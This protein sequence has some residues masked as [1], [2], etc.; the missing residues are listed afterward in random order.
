MWERTEDTI[1]LRNHLME[2]VNGNTDNNNNNNGENN[3]N[4]NDL[5]DLVQEYQRGQMRLYLLVR[6]VLVPHIS[7]VQVKAENTGIGGVYHNKGGIMVHVCLGQT[8]LTFLTAH[9]AAHEG[10]TQYK[11]RNDH[12]REILRGARPQPKHLQ[13]QDASIVSHHMFVMGDL[14]YRL[15]I[16]SSDIADAISDDDA[17]KNNKSGGDGG[18]S[19]TSHKSS[20]N[21]K[22]DVAAALKIINEG[23]FAKLYSYDELWAGIQKKEVLCQFQTMPCHFSPTFKVQRTKGFQY[24]TQRVPR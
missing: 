16:P 10:S 6:K 7:Q 23:D 1:L 15:R 8:R 4:T 18:S 9:L 24:K 21:H 17:G 11:S 2:I 22:D 13:W 14:N 12:V 20:S 3:S 19:P 5:Y